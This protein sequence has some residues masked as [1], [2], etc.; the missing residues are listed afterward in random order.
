M[1]TINQTAGSSRS[2]DNFAAIF[3]AALNEYENVTGKPL[4]AQPF[5]TQLD[6]CDTPQAIS[7]VLRSQAQAF[8]ESPSGNEKLMEYLGPTVDV[9][10]TF[11]GTLGE[12]IGLV[13]RLTHFI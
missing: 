10:F 11:S 8:N 1:S 5:A 4:R 12:G 6:G 13:R 9:L 2:N 7:N 3:Q